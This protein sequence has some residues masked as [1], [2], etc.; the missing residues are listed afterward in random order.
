MLGNSTAFLNC[1][2]TLKLRIIDSIY[3]TFDYWDFAALKQ[4]L[5]SD[6]DSFRDRGVYYNPADPFSENLFALPG[7][8]WK[9]LRMKLTFS[10]A[11]MKEQNYLKPI[12]DKSEIVPIEEILTRFD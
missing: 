7:Q 12:A 10:S 8:K 6:F 5:V 4:M 1:Q 2:N 3:F 9:A 11:K